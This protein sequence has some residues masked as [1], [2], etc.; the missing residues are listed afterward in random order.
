[1]TGIDQTTQPDVGMTYRELAEEIF[2]TPS[3]PTVGKLFYITDNQIEKTI[4]EDILSD[5]T[6]TVDSTLTNPLFTWLCSADLCSTNSYSAN[7]CP[8]DLEFIDVIFLDSILSDLITE[9]PVL[10]II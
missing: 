5:I 1:M 10:G 8:T 9:L 3:E 4:C 6:Q 7:L 2:G